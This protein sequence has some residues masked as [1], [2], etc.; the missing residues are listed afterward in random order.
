VFLSIDAT[1]G[2]SVPLLHTWADPDFIKTREKIIHHTKLFIAYQ[3]ELKFE[4]LSG[5]SGGKIPT[6]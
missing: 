6:F 4:S 3:F 1:R 2:S 5:K